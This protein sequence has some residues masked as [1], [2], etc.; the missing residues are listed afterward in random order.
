MIKDKFP[1]VSFRNKESQPQ[2]SYNTDRIILGWKLIR[3]KEF[4]LAIEAFNESLKEKE[5]SNS[6]MG[7]GWALNK[8]NQFSKSIEIFSR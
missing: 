2:E 3:N 6:L 5:N 1:M 8:T 4:F 7:L